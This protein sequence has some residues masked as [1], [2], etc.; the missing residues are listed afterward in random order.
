MKMTR[1]HAIFFETMDDLCVEGDL[2]PLFYAFQD[3]FTEC[4]LNKM[5]DLEVH[6][7]AKECLKRYQHL[8]NSLDVCLSQLRCSVLEKLNLDEAEW[9][10]ANRI[11]YEEEAE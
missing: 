6:L 7:K 4:D 1:E 8:W 9:E 5:S 2:E 3:F 11:F 10:H